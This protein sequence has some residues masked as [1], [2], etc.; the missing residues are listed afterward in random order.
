[1]TACTHTHT[2]THTTVYDDD[3]YHWSLVCFRA[4][5]EDD[6]S[7]RLS[8]RR[9]KEEETRAETVKTRSTVHTVAHKHTHTHTHTQIYIYIY[10]SGVG[11]IFKIGGDRDI[12]I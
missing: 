8:V 5:A 3:G 11:L 2:H 1:M 6:S 12:N 4:S 7:G 10:Y 9:E